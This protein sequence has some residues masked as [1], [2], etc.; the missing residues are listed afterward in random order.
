MKTSVEWLRQYVDI[1][2]D[3]RE[4]SSR[5]TGAGLEVEG[6]E[7][8]GTIPEGVVTAKILSRDPHP[9]S[10]HL[11]VC[12]VT[13]GTEEFQI[14]CGAPNCDA[15]CIV[16]LA[17]LGTRFP[18]GTH[19]KKSKLRGVESFG[20]MCSSRE[21]GLSEDHSGLMILPADTPLDVPLT[22]LIPCD[23][24]IDWEV[25]PNRPDWLSHIGIAR[26]IGA[27]SGN[28][29]RLPEM[30][31]RED[32]S[33]TIEEVASVT[34]EAPDLC[35]RYIARVFDNVKIGPSPDW[36]V[37]RLEAVGLRSINNVVDITNYVM[38]EFGNPLHAFDLKT[39]T[40]GAIIVRRAKDKEEITT[41]DGTKLTLTPENLLIADKTRGVALAGIMGGEN[42]MITDDTTTVLLEAA[43]FDRSNIRISSRTLGKATDSSYRYERGVSPWLTELA[44]R[45]A[46]SLLCE[47]CGA[48]QRK[49]VIDRIGKSWVCAEIPFQ[50]D[51]CNRWLGLSLS[52]DQML[53][54][55]KRRGL[56][57]LSQD[58]TKAILRAPAWRF[59]LLAEHDLYEEVAQMM[60]MDNIPEAPV[61]ARLT[62]TMKDDKFLPL[63]KARADFLA[64]GLDEI[65]NYTMWSLPQ[66]LAGSGLKEEDI[67]KVSNGIS[68]DTAYLRPTL[69][70]GLLE[71]VNHNVSRGNHDLRLFETGRVF[72][73]CDGKRTERTMAAVALTGRPQPDRYGADLA[74]VYDFYDMK[75]VVEA[76]LAKLGVTNCEWKP[77]ESDAYKHGAAAVYGV[78]KSR[79]QF[80]PLVTFGEA[81]PELVKGI[82]LR[83]PLFIAQ[84]ELEALLPMAKGLPKYQ[85]IPQYPSTSRDVSFV[86]PATLTHKMVVDAIRALHLPTLEKVQLFDI[87]EDEKV[88]GKGRR[89]MA[90]NITFRNPERTIT[91]EEGNAMQEKIR[92]ALAGLGV[93]LR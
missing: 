37:R 89:S 34:L 57:L 3:A 81:S 77:L 56:E 92:Q 69:L 11:S 49:G 45:R 2:W 62:G 83:Y 24:V 9:N 16:P 91:D 59:D 74:R 42:S 84:L 33:K 31:I 1:P 78:Q 36:M 64:L 51:R 82:R 27:V 18:D 40:D 12:R 17:T 15:G 87:F 35:T 14:V 44:S 54:C 55:L 32:E 48:V 85:A 46:A 70:P 90:Y 20:M 25:T 41:L 30:P 7:E 86:A 88:L 8:H 50:F 5:L 72:C 26:E 71:V 10:D 63:E 21:L 28:P 29:M 58:E 66:C 75:G 76:W 6:I 67:L 79:D 19:I 38:L 80:L 65:M 23:T 61:L 4:L 43:T 53:D 73:W 93:E 13:T 60:G 39:L 52:H 68:N 47:L 22:S